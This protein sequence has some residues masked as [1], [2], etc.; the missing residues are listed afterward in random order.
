MLDNDISTAGALR[1]L[2]TPEAAFANSDDG[3]TLDRRRFLQL[4]GMGLG[5]GMVAGPGSSLLDTALDTLS[6]NADTSWAAGPIG[7][8]DGILVVLGMFG[9]NDGLNT[10]V[11]INDGEYYS[12]HGELAIPADQTLRI[13][14]ATGLNPELTALK[15]FWDNDQLAIVEGVGYPDPDLSHFNS[16]A[17]WMHGR[18]SGIP[19]SGW[20]G[21]W[22]DGYLNGSKDLFAAAE[23]GYSLPLH[24][25]GES[26]RATSIPASRPAFGAGSSERDQRQY[27]TV[28]DLSSASTTHWSQE[29]GQAFV[30]QLD[31]ARQIAPAIPEVLPE[32][33]LVARLEVQ[34]RL[35]NANL[36]F[37]VLSAGWG[38][39]DSHAGQPD[40]HPLRMEELNAAIRRFYAV[41]HPRWANRVTFIT[42]SEFGRTSQ[43]N[44]GAG[45]D[46]G[47]AAPHFVF[48]ANVKGGLYGQRPTLAGLGRWGRMDHHVDFRDYFGSV[49][50]G[51][52]GGGSTDV[53]GRTTDDLGLFAAAP[54]STVPGGPAIE[55]PSTPQ[56]G[57]YTG[58]EPAVR[59]QS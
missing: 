52:L 57:S 59:G 45:T 35:I 27:Q 30:D 51:W 34:A 31:V 58:Y 11:P 22:L 43:A 54:G 42:F 55:P 53:F 17:T 16:M 24:M 46:H 49:I 8:G 3:H 44:D 36:G 47:T 15:E 48:G 50:D 14:G 19:T 33:D 28:R 10:V 29:I 20:V 6:G 5:A 37:R 56:A 9:G 2:S 18:M 4:I 12:Q 39:F 40:Q 41:L 21:R 7:A 26:S 38:D 32:S 25:R 13:N 1:H 23:V